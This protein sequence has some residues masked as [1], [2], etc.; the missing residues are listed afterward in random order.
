MGPVCVSLPFSLSH[1]VIARKLTKLPLVSY[2]ASNAY[3]FYNTATQATTWTNPLETPTASTSTA[4]PDSA[5][6]SADGPPAPE[7]DGIDYGGI[8]PDLAYLDPT[9]ARA[10]TA[11]G[12]TPA[13]QARF[14]SRTGRF[15]VR[16]PI[17]STV[18]VCR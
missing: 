12:A 10:R 8:D 1:N 6:P 4:G 5:T 11:G 9:L 7:G 14:N 16:L 18:T 2:S 17:R 3:Y 15:Q 13:F